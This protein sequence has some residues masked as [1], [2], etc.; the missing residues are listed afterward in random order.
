MAKGAYMSRKY[1]GIKV[2]PPLKVMR[3]VSYP[4]VFS[5]GN[6][7]CWERSLLFAWQEDYRISP[8]TRLLLR[9]FPSAAQ[10][11]GSVAVLNDDSEQEYVLSALIYVHLRYFP[12]NISK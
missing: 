10:L 6:F 4:H 12:F 3:D 2:Q 11:K 1:K 7:K 9:Q 8:F 5:Y